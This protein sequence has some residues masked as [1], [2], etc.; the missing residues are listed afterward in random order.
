MNKTLISGALD[1]GDIRIDLGISG[2]GGDS[3]FRVTDPSIK[4]FWST[5]TIKTNITE[6][7]IRNGSH[8][9]SH[10]VKYS[11]R[12]VTI[13]FIVKAK[14]R[15]EL[16]DYK[17]V[18]Q[19]FVGTPHTRFEVFDGSNSTYVE[20]MLSIEY[21][22]DID[23]RVCSGEMTLTCIDA[24]RKSVDEYSTTIGLGIS[25]NGGGG[26][27]FG[28]GG[29]GLV[30]PMNFGKRDVTGVR[31]TVVVTNGGSYRSDIRIEA[32]GELPGA[33]F[34]WYDSDGNRGYLEFDGYISPYQ[35]IV[36]DSKTE[37][38]T[39]DG[40]DLSGQLQYR[41]FPHIPAGGNVRITM[42]STS[43]SFNYGNAK[44]KYNYTWM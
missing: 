25:G 37:T 18:L 41:D 19:R 5:P 10:S 4:G 20:G 42:L 2:V 14:N 6:S 32:N 35:T 21:S 11:S 33:L 26:M 30:F 28:T 9:L 16:D 39:L 1:N 24:E 12:V 27:S 38:A 43:S 3:P 40:T 13:P 15:A 8:G 44:I 31:N 17:T 36:L 22:R 34:E 7:Q 29:K 23:E